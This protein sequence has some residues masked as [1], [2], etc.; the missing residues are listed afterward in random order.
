MQT[1]EMSACVSVNLNLYQ[2]SAA[3]LG[4]EWRMKTYM[5]GPLLKTD[6]Y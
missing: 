4:K 2:S 5:A 1:K 3:D 6:P